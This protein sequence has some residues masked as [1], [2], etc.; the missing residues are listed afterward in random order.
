MYWRY[1]EHSVTGCRLF[2]KYGGQLYRAWCS[3]RVQ[4]IRLFQRQS[5]AVQ[6]YP[7]E[8]AQYG[9]VSGYYCDLLVQYDHRIP[10][11]TVPPG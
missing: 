3:D 4:P 5:T 6:C 10:R 9:M 2:T 11:D 8:D 7:T 1:A